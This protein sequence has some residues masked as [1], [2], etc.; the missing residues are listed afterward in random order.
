M[1]LEAFDLASVFAAGVALGAGYAAM[2]WITVR[3]LAQ[4]RYPAIGLLGSAVV[5]LAL[6][7]GGLYVVMDGRWERLLIG[8]LGFAVARFVATRLAAPVGS[9]PRL[10]P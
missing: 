4:M 7:L 1:G 3:R 10:I 8:L 6:P 9:K 5:R 2:L